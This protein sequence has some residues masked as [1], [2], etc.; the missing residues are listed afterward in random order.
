MPGYAARPPLTVQQILAWADAHYERTGRWPTRNSGPVQEAPGETWERIHGAL[1]E[2]YR[3]LPGSDSLA[4]LLDRHGRKRAPWRGVRPWTP[5]EDEQV[6][7]LP[8]QEAAR[9]TRRNV[10]SVHVRR[11]EL[12]VSNEFLG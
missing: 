2:G 11:Y 7:A 3:G 9:R 12:G 6:R 4:Q 10:L 8:P 5:E 1:N